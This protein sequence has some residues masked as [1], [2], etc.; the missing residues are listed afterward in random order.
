MRPLVCFL[1]DDD[2]EE[3]EIFSYATEELSVPV[4]F[5]RASTGA[6]AITALTE[7]HIVPDII[8][9][10][11][12]MPRMDGKECLRRMKALPI[13]AGVPVILYSTGLTDFQR[14][15]M[16]SAGADGIMEKASNIPELSRQLETVLK[17]A[18]VK[19]T[20]TTFEAAPPQ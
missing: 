19:V 17:T 13:L 18:L 12:Y 15:E 7:G 4:R 8:F 14:G 16:E 6:E 3:S 2:H 5:V 9:L 11:L 1:I 20:D 10:D